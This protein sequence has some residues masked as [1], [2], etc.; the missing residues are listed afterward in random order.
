[1]LFKKSFFALITLALF[2]SL[3]QATTPKIVGLI[4]VRNES[5]I[6]EQCLRALA[7]YTDAI[8]CLDDASTDN[9]LEIIRSLADKYH[10]ERIITKEVWHLDEPGNRNKLLQ[11]GREIGGTHFIAID[12]DEVLTANFLN[13]KD[14]DEDNELR[15]MILQLKPGEKIK[16]NWILFWRSVNNYRFDN[17]IWTHN[18]K[19][20][21]FCD[22]GKCSHN[23]EFIHTPRTPGNLKGKI[24]TVKGY[25]RGMLHFQFVNWRN[26]LVKQAW[27]RCLERI[28]QP[29]KSDKAINQ[30]YAPSKNE[31]NL[32]LRQSH[33]DWLEGY[34]FFDSTVYDR[35][36]GWREKQV[37]GWF[38]EYGKDHFAGLDIWDIDW[39]SGLLS[40][41]RL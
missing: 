1:M 12:A 27:Y 28:R 38:Q 14:E 32:G 19:N 25:D 21:I 3:A 2:T 11:A 35:P 37:L 13:D 15:K 18:Y 20:F 24:Y 22:D 7:L 4:P 23:S 30:R 17:S 34:S 16:L 36:E 6:I 26:L 40:D 9:T 39:A 33:A 41:L 8:V 29:K 31:K 5:P 10:I